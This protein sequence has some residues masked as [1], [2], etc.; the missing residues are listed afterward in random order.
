MTEMAAPLMAPAQSIMGYENWSPEEVADY[1]AQKG[2]ADYRS[3]FVENE[4]SGDRI[5]L[6]TQEDIPDLGIE[7]VGHRVGI[8][9]VLRSLKSKARMQLR[10]Q[11]IAREEEAYD[12]CFIAERFYTCCGLCPRDPDQYILKAGKLQIKE[13]EITRICG[14]WKCVC[15]GGSWRNDNITLDR[16][17]DVDTI[18]T[19]SGLCCC[20]VTKTKVQIAV[21]AGSAAESEEAR[22]T[23]K[24]LF[25]DGDNSAFP[26]AI[27]RAAEE[28]IIQQRGI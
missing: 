8:L 13:F 28:Y 20:K 7:I 16:I 14:S 22:V 12:G 2:Y 5:V 4:L 23:Q 17:K 25:I 11:E 18:V 1:F 10:K 24:E 15:L 19:T 6:M 9:K 26:D 3:V 27:L 21:G